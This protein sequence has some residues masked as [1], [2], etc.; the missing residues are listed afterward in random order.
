LLRRFDGLREEWDA[1]RFVPSKMQAL[2]NVQRY[3]TVL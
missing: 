2:A 1:R 3:S